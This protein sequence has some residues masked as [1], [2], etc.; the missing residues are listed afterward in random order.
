MDNGTILSLHCWAQVSA[1]SSS[2]AFIT[3]LRWGVLNLIRRT[4]QRVVL[5]V[6][7]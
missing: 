2:V 4:W 3:E 5:A 6:S 1:V 7:L